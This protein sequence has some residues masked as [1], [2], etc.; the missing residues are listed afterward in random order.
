MRHLDKRQHLGTQKTL[1]GGQI[2]LLR[3]SFYDYLHLLSCSICQLAEF[4]KES[5]GLIHIL[6]VFEI[7]WEE[8]I[9]L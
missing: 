1:L 4:M 3:Q 7:M 6:K 5:H 2:Y 9:F 8:G